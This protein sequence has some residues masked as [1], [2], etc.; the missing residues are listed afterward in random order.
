MSDH[1]VFSLV[2]LEAARDRRLSAAHYRVL[3]ALL[4]FR[5]RDTNLVWPSRERVS[6]I[7]GYPVDKI[8]RLTTELVR[9]GW[10]EKSQR[11]GRA[12]EYRIRVPDLGPINGETVTDEVRVPRL[13]PGPHPAAETRPYPR[14]SDQALPPGVRPI[15]Q[16]R[17]QTKE[18]TI[19]RSYLALRARSAPR[20]WRAGRLPTR[21]SSSAS[22]P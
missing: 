14:G 5:G 12:C 19:A 17:E 21:T 3:I 4:S 15:E 6:E 8:S 7:T 2:P 13:S 22:D 11:G 18:Q 10:I 9:Y 16:T 20:R 1:H